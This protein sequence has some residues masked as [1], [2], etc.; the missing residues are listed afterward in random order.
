MTKTKKKSSKLLF[1][2]PT[3]NKT[4]MVHFSLYSVVVFLGRSLCWF[5]SQLSQY[6]FFF[7]RKSL[8]WGVF[9][10]HFVEVITLHFVIISE[11]GLALTFRST[12]AIVR[13]C[14]IWWRS[15]NTRLCVFRDLQ[16]A[17]LPHFSALIF[18]SLIFTK[19]IIAQ[20][21]F[22]VFLE[23]LHFIVTKDYTKWQNNILFQNWHKKVTINAQKFLN[24]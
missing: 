15:A 13:F 21:I 3:R 20:I 18:A 4:T 5:T 2:W 10:W 11:D 22:V 24:I 7:L 12:Q 6:W 16:Y 8:D 14:H 19:N 1:Y 23:E 9:N 17:L